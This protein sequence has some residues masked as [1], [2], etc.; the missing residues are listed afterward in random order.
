[1]TLSRAY[2]RENAESLGKRVS[3]KS[4][5]RHLRASYV[6]PTTLDAVGTGNDDDV[7]DDSEARRKARLRA[8][9]AMERATSLCPCNSMLGLASSAFAVLCR[10]GPPAVPASEKALSSASFLQDGRERLSF[11]I[12]WRS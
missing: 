11:D 8:T 9:V 7:D 2:Q 1:M 10:A 3:Q 5:L 4:S 12:S 6:G